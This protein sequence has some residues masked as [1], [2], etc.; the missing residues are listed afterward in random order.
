MADNLDSYKISPNSSSDLPAGFTYTE[1]MNSRSKQEEMEVTAEIMTRDKMN[2]GTSEFFPKNATRAYSSNEVNSGNANSSWDGMISEIYK[3]KKEI[4]RGFNTGSTSSD[5]K[6]AIGKRLSANS[7]AAEGALGIMSNIACGDGL[8]GIDFKVHELARAMDLEIDKMSTYNAC[9]R[10]VTK[11]PI[12]GLIKSISRLEAGLEEL[13]NLPGKMFNDLIDKVIGTID[14][15]GLPEDLSNCLGTKALNQLKVGHINSPLGL[16][17]KLNKAYNTQIC[18][19][20]KTGI[21][22]NSEIM[23]KA[24]ATPIVSSAVSFDEKTMLSFATA[25]IESDAIDNK[26]LA[27]SL[28]STITDKPNSNVVNT[29]IFLAFIKASKEKD[30]VVITS[31]I[32]SINSNIHSNNSSDEI[33]VDKI[34]ELNESGEKMNALDIVSTGVKKDET[35]TEVSTNIKA[36]DVLSTMCDDYSDSLDAES[37]YDKILKLI[38]L[39]DSNFDPNDLIYKLYLNST[40]ST[41]AKL[42]IKSRNYV[43]NETSVTERIFLEDTYADVVLRKVNDEFDVKDK[44]AIL[45]MLNEDNRLVSV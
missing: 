22:T 29:L 25:M 23:N 38:S 14:K 20:S 45:S 7:H 8:T 21:K 33:I 39:L 10:K 3:A 31:N 12:E 36:E 15:L 27:D 24:I 34:I 5:Y 42:L 19:S 43:D 4:K 26:I 18:S 32:N 35:D 2:S 37:D 30:D 9:G 1:I 6:N 40:I 16:K 17:D 28:T 11:N 13:I 44:V 41:L